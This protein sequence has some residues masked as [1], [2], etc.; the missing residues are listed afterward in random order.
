MD[1]RCYTEHVR[2]RTTDETDSIQSA[3]AS[4]NSKEQDHGKCMYEATAAATQLNSQGT[5]A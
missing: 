3:T 5:I 4:A 2:E 1:G